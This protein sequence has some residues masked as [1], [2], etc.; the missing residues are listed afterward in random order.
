MCWFA[1]L[2]LGLVYT[3]EDLSFLDENIPNWQVCSVWPESST[4][5]PQYNALE[6]IVHAYEINILISNKA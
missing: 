4:L 1:F 2:T 3:G 6:I 5:L